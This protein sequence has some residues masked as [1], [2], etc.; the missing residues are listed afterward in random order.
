ML[1][2]DDHEVVRRGLLAFLDSEPDI[3]VVGE[4]GG[5]AQALELLASMDVG[6]PPARRDRH[7]PADGAGRRDRVD[8][9]DP[10]PLQR[11][12]GR[13]THLVRRGGARARRARGGGVG[14]PAQGLRRGRGGGRGPGRAP[15]R[16]AARS[17]RS[18]AAD[19]LASRGGGTATRVRAH[20]PGARRASA[21]G[22]RASRTR[23]S[24]RSSRSAS[25]RRGPTYPGS[26]ASSASAR[27]RRPRYGRSARDSWTWT[28]SAPA[29]SRRE[30]IPSFANTLRRCHST[31]RGLRKSRAPISGFE[32]PS[33]A[34]WAICC[35]WAVSSSRDSTRPLAHLLARR[36]ELAPGSL[37]E[38]LHPDRGEHV[39]GGP[40]LRASVDAPVAR[41]AA[42]PR[43]AGGCARAP[44]AAACG[45]G[46]RSP[47][48]RARSAPPRRRGARWNG[49]VS[50]APSRSAPRPSPRRCA[51]ERAARARLVA[52]RG[53]LEQLGRGPHG[54]E[55]LRRVLAGLARGRQRLVVPPEAVQ[56]HRPRPVPVLHRRP[57]AAGR[58]LLDRR[59]DHAEASS[60]A[61]RMARE[62]EGAVRR[63]ARAGRLGDRV[64]LRHQRGRPRELTTEHRRL[65]RHVRAHRQHRQRPRLTSQLDAAIRD[66]DTGVVVPHHHG[67]GRREPA[68][69]E[70]LLGRDVR[71][72]EAGGSLGEKRSR[73]T[74]AVGEREG[75]AVEQQVGRARMVGADGGRSRLAR[76]LGHV[77]RA[78]EA[79][80]EESRAPGVEVRLSRNPRVERLEP[81]RGSQE[82][83]RSV[84]PAALRVGGLG[85][86][87]VEAGVLQLVQR[88]HL[89][90]RQE[91]AR[92][93]ER[94]RAEARLG[95]R[96]RPLRSPRRDRR[97]GRQPAAGTPPP[98]P[99]RRA[100]APG[101]PSAPAPRRPPRR[102][103][104]PPR[105]GATHDGPG[106]CSGRSPRRGPD[107]PL[108]A[109]PGRRPVDGR[110]HQ[111]MTERH[112]FAHLQQ[113]VAGRSAAWA[114]M[115]RRSDARRRRS[116][117]PTG[118]AAASRSKSRASVPSVSSRRM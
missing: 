24:P 36:D 40:E 81:L 15:G 48:G 51:R 109:R 74:A 33:R 91:A 77:G 63:D 115:P 35:S 68:P 84:A 100:P 9:P 52:P 71:A 76:H 101:P 47:L 11:H 61:P 25:A 86:K 22:A 56:Q 69:A 95:S 62:H 27:G 70:H 93:V 79:P 43:T 12:R 118:S 37:G 7:G 49:R 102:G 88:A 6:G 67:G 97:S 21:R 10:R 75:E 112:P 65:R 1:V 111:R 50:P 42:T 31:V 106:R 66:G 114:A 73:G 32:S 96:E 117:S 104:R 105:R 92:H 116:G 16:A 46:A 17:R 80:G 3:E 39:V 4:A 99:G 87:E 54:D 110:A 107:A 90:C 83:R 13:G 18:P 89:G 94:A 26:S 45:R 29:S 60:A 28:R 58:G 108:G 64:G 30:W 57:L 8:P 14:L 72:R 23:R 53:G 113:P 41:G 103:P 59:V 5:G 19:V 20:V 98:R 34:S 78:R 38:R 55:Q 85:A 2:V 44:G 82:E